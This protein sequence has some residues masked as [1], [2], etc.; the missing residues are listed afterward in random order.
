M[1][2]VFL[3]YILDFALNVYFLALIFLSFVFLRL[4]PVVGPELRKLVDLFTMMPTE[5][6]RTC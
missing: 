2:S 6:F 3:V 5:E 4:F 1:I